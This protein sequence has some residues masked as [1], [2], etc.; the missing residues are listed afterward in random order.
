MTAVA[1][2]GCICYLGT[3]LASL[4]G[5]PSQSITVI[6]GLTVTA[7]TLLPK[8][9]APLAASA[10]GLAL[11]LMQV[12]WSCVCVQWSRAGAGAGA[13]GGAPRSKAP[14]LA[15]FLC[16]SRCER[17]HPARG[18]DCP[19]PLLLVLHRPGRPPG[20]AAGAGAAGWVY[21]QGAAALVKR[22][23]WR[24]VGW[25][26]CDGPTR[27]ACSAASTACSCVARSPHHPRTSNAQGRRRSLA[28]L[29]PR[30]GGACWCLPCWS[31]RW[32]TR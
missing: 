14:P 20:A 26:G 23:H 11:L 5:A 3:Q 19:H 25:D 9:L 4:W 32:A 16:R 30:V 29:P 10:E 15:G 17:Q 28:W 12:G 13:G 2:S 21:A 1:L 6:T 8:Q 18:D 27:V 7:A 22:K 31:A 24:C